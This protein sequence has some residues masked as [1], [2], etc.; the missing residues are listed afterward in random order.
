MLLECAVSFS[1]RIEDRSMNG[2]FVCVLDV[3]GTESLFG[4]PL[5]LAKHLR[6]QFTVN[7]RFAL[8]SPIDGQSRSLKSF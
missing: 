6:Q 4:P 3:S 2:V 8:K 5:M 1:S 7:E